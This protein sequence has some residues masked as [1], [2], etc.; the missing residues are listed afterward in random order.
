M[1]GL[2]EVTVEENETPEER[3]VEPPDLEPLRRTSQHPTRWE[4]TWDQVV[5]FFENRTVH[6]V[7]LAIAIVAA[8]ALGYWALT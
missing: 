1:P 4:R 8:I 5:A 3:M 6:L 7:L 2:P